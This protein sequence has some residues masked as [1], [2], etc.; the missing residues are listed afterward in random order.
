MPDDNTNTEVVEE[1]V[2]DEPQ[3][4]PQENVET[5]QPSEEV[6]ETPE[7]PEETPQVPEEKPE[8]PETN[9]ER[10]PSRRETLR[11][12]HLLKKYGPPPERP[13]P[14]N[15]RP[16]ALNYDEAL[17]A[18]PEVIRRLEADREAT[19]QRQYNA[20][21]EQAKTIQFETRLDVDAP[22]VESKYKFLNPSDKQ[23]FDPV[24]ADAMNT[25]YLDTVGYD[26]GDAQR[27]IP[28]SVQNPNIRYRDF[29]EAQ[30]EFA[31]ALMADR[32]TETVKEVG[33]QASQTGLR[34][35]GSSAKRMNLNKDPSEMS[36]EELYASIGQKPPKK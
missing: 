33:K 34:P 32:V 27:G 26:A 28:P 9:E 7:T 30:M 13:A 5:P 12:Q 35:D 19:G 18:D 16:D 24:R 29:V 1:V 20:G 22:Q 23:N 2:A 11:I 14:S 21:L 25:L 31:E 4:V 8:V 6:V 17:D 36:L 15:Q 10:P 3:D